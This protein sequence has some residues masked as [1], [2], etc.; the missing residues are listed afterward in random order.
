LLGQRV[1]ILHAPASAE[2]GLDLSGLD[3]DCAV[4]GL[5]RRWPLRLP[6]GWRLCQTLHYDLKGWYWVIERSGE[7]LCLDTIEDP[8]GLGRDGFPTSTFMEG[9]TLRPSPGV[10]AAYLTA[11]RIRKGDLSGQE[12]ERIGT[13]ARGDLDRYLEA[14]DAVVGTTLAR[15]LAGNAI[16]GCPPDRGAL[17]W[18]RRRQL[19]RRYRTPARAITALALGA[20]RELERV[21]YPT[22]L[23]VLVAGPDGSGKSTLADAL[24]DLC[25]GMFRRETRQHWRPGLLPRPGAFLGREL[26]DPTRPHARPPH[27]RALSTALLLYYWL[28]FL[29]G[30]WLRTVPLRIRTGLVV[31]ER[32]WWD[33]AVDPRRYRLDVP[34]QLVQ[35]LGALL[36][37][38]DLA[39][40]LESEPALLRER[41]PELPE[42]E[43][44]RQATAWR[45][46]LP[47]R[48]RRQHL[49]ASRPLH[50]VA[51]E[52]R[53]RIVD[54]LET[55]AT[56]RLGAGWSALPRR[57]RSRWIL[58]RGTRAA[59]AAALGIYHPMTGRGRLGWEAARLFASSGGFRLLPRGEGPPRQVAKALAAHLPPRSTLAVAR[60]THPGR[61]RYLALIV[62]EQGQLHGV[63][64]VATDAD[65]ARALDQEATLIEAV[66]RLLPS[67]LS[68]PGILCRE[69][70]LLLLGAVD[71][72]PRRSPWR[73]DEAV[74]YALGVFFR[75]GAREGPELLG[76]VHGDFAP[77]NLLRTKDGWVLIDWE[78]ASP[79][80]LPYFDLCHYLVQ[81][82]VLLGRPSS[83]VLLE[84]FCY[85]K[86][87]VGRTVHA[88]ADGASV[89]AA[90]AEAFL[91]SYLI[92]S[93]S[94]LRPR[95]AEER[96][97]LTARRRLLAALGS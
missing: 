21:I 30:G 75:N 92:I 80:Q 66:G 5:D 17:R 60:M 39:L 82:H 62:G 46:V 54:L 35:A 15:S 20:R 55:R 51:A 73:L 86:G 24:P 32:G 91:R 68:A 59:A 42:A 19:V 28:D 37:R 6:D 44:R 89:P 79:E 8:Q 4:A 87:W 9:G 95:T 49:D 2:T 78:D 45:A 12:W 11:K 76:P 25:R 61:G 22:G 74:A 53:K 48:V 67:P 34:S 40:V 85:G 83:R 10:Q 52:S 70:G 58:P 88:Y 36:P 43:L 7:V 33:L 97:G 96:D 47:H 77:W 23:L 3:V 94:K 13:L 63:A 16:H 72:H 1:L 81:A 18:L 41:K 64:K 26:G 29:L 38:P 90:Q 56:S 93:P 69:P 71:W 27:G 84:G 50:E 57:G 65:A 14:L 31:L